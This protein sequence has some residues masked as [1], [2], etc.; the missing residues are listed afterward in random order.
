[1]LDNSAFFLLL[2]LSYPS[3]AMIAAPWLGAALSYVPIR[4]S[5][6]SKGTE[7]LRNVSVWL[8]SLGALIIMAA[9]GHTMDIV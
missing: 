3:I 5:K 1:M 9:S 4:L 6:R 7:R 2:A 8:F